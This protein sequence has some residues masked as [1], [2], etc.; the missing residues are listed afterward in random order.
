MHMAVVCQRLVDGIATNGLDRIDWI[1]SHHGGIEGK[2]S[3]GE[4]AERK[5]CHVRVV[6]SLEQ[7]MVCEKAA[8]V[9]RAR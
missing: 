5:S 9:G 7:P 3:P 4:H 6:L 8:W 2:A 1:S